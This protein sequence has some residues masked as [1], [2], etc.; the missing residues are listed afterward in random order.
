M[1]DWEH[2]ATIDSICEDLKIIEQMLDVYHKPDVINGYIDR[3]KGRDT[4]DARFVADELSR[5][6]NRREGGAK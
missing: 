2:K 4:P 3:L 6:Y 5:N 1:Q